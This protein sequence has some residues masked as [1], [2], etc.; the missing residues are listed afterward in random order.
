MSRARAISIFVG[1]GVM[2][3]VGL[4]A[5]GVVLAS[6]FGPSPLELERRAL[7]HAKL[8]LDHAQRLLPLLEVGSWDPAYKRAGKLRGELEQTTD[9]LDRALKKWALRGQSPLR[10]ELDSLD[11]LS[12]VADSLDYIQEKLS[13]PQPEEITTSTQNRLIERAEEI[14]KDLER[15]VQKI[16]KAIE[17]RLA[18]AP[19]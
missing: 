15:V 6:C 2:L 18:P 17:K 10:W 8:A 5:L 14:A 12:E 4:V 7:R 9:F 11:I 3:A 16:E 13:P 1:H 19:E